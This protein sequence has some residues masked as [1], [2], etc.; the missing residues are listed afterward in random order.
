MSENKVTRTVCRNSFEFLKNL[1]AHIKIKHSL[2]NIDSIAP[3]KKLKNKE[4]YVFSCN[5]CDKS[6]NFIF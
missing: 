1:R 3:I 2:T 6:T 5:E 4:L